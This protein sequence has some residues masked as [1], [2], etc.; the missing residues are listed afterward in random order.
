MFYASVAFSQLPDNS[1]WDLDSLQYNPDE[2]TSDFDMDVSAGWFPR[3]YSDSKFLWNV[4]FNTG[5]VWSDAQFKKQNELGNAVN[6]WEA[7]FDMTVEERLIRKKYSKDTDA[8]ILTTG[9]SEFGAAVIYPFFNVAYLN[10]NSAFYWQ[11]DYLADV[12]KTKQYRTN[13]NQ[14]KNFKE[15]NIIEQYEYGI[16]YS[17]NLNVPVYGGSMNVGVHL[18]SFYYMTAGVGGKYVIHS[19]TLQYLQIASEKDK[20]SFANG[21]DTLHVMEG[22]TIESVEYLKYHI[23][24]GIG[25]NI[26]ADTVNAGF[27]ILYSFPVNDVLKDVYWRQHIGKLSIYLGI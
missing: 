19:E 12:Y 3:L 5:D 26:I 21:W 2:F 23:N 11:T 13:D 27:E 20:I 9:F 15:A 16:D 24:L 17:L 18:A 4:Y 1:E 8:A 10:M 25:L 6:Q 22:R 14:I 7:Y